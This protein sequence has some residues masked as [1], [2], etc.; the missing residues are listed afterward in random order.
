MLE[1]C[2]ALHKSSCNCVL[3]SLIL[4]NFKG[5]GCHLSTQ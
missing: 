2:F 5:A 1:V 4:V 3:Y